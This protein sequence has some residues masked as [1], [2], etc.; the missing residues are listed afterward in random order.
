M[1]A[2]NVTS[3]VLTLRACTCSSL[4]SRLLSSWPKSPTHSSESSVSPELL[5]HDSAGVDTVTFEAELAGKWSDIGG[6][7]EQGGVTWALEGLDH[8][9]PHGLFIANDPLLLR[10]CPPSPGWSDT[11]T[12]WPDGCP[13]IGFSGTAGRGMAL[14]FDIDHLWRPPTWNVNCSSWLEPCLPCLWFPTGLCLGPISLSC[15]GESGGP[16]LKLR[17][18][19]EGGNGWGWKLPGLGGGKLMAF[20]WRLCPIAAC[21]ECVHMS[22]RLNMCG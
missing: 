4:M 7:D 5:N 6:R 17:G 18:C 9:V 1:C 20:G 16:V 2:I 10:N 11:S 15:W 8:D 21:W 3:L 14:K 12:P 22:A 19:P 13:H